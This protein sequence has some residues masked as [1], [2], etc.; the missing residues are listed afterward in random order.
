MLG[1]HRPNAIGPFLRLSALDE[2]VVAVMHPAATARTSIDRSTMRREWNMVR[3]LCLRTS[4]LGALSVDDFV[5]GESS[6][7]PRM[8]W[9]AWLCHSAS[10]AGGSLIEE[11]VQDTTPASDRRG[12]RFLV[13]SASACFLVLGAW[14]LVGDIWS[15]LLDTAVAVGFLAA[16]VVWSGRRGRQAQAA[17]AFV[18]GACWCLAGFGPTVS[19]IWWPALAAAVLPLRPDRPRA[20]RFAAIAFLGVAAVV[21][22]FG[23]YRAGEAF[24]LLGAAVVVSVALAQAESHP[25]ATASGEASTD[26]LAGLFVGFGIALPAVL[27]LSDHTSASWGMVVATISLALAGG[28]LVKIAWVDPGL[29]LDVTDRVIELSVMPGAAGMTSLLPV[30]DAAR[31][32]QAY[33]AGMAMVEANRALVL[34][35]ERQVATS[36]ALQIRLVEA[37]DGERAQLASQLKSS[38]LP[39]LAELTERLRTVEIWV[40]RPKLLTEVNNALTEVRQTIDDL[41]RTARGLHPR[42]VSEAGLRAALLDLARRLP[43]DVT[44]SAPAERFAATV[45]NTLWYVC[46]ESLTNT[47]KHAHATRAWIDV[48]RVGGYVVANVRDDGLGCDASE[49]ESQ[50]GGGLASVRDR[51]IASGGTLIVRNLETRGL[52][53]EAKVPC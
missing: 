41:D 28:C 38:V 13:L 36:R 37:A 46:A 31:A 7:L 12:V 43:I 2:A 21:R 32:P 39:L 22:G 8:S 30:G 26:T 53:V 52:S 15:H 34:D 3:L 49:F 48:Q 44:A 45:E 47:V 50:R 51:V 10:V 17:T 19:A 18:S 1:F 33:A 24:A 4:E 23:A 9:A 42:L 29:D 40:G 5:R 6:G 11:R 14:A 16:S 35:L 20:G 25:H 27:A